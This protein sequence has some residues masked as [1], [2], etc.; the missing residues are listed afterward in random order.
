MQCPVCKSKIDEFYTVCPVCGFFGLHMDFVNKE[1]ALHWKK[2]IL[3]YYQ[4][5]WNRKQLG[6]PIQVNL[7]SADAIEVFEKYF[8]DEH[9]KYQ[10]KV[11][12]NLNEAVI[13]YAKWMSLQLFPAIS[14][15][16]NTK[17]SVLTIVA[18]GVVF[19]HDYLEEGIFYAISNNVVSVYYDSE[20][21]DCICAV[22]IDDRRKRTEFITVLEFARAGTEH[23]IF[24]FDR[25]KK[26][27]ESLYQA[28]VTFADF[29]SGDMI[30]PISLYAE[31]DDFDE[32]KKYED[33][34]EHRGLCKI[35]I[36][37][38]SSYKRQAPAFVDIYKEDSSMFIGIN[39]VK[40]TKK[41]ILPQ[42]IHIPLGQGD[43]TL[44]YD[45]DVYINESKSTVYVGSWKSYTAFRFEELA[46]ARQMFN[47][48]ALVGPCW[49]RYG[50]KE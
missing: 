15:D 20:K 11:G 24:P 7:S 40:E 6:D 2:S 18:D 43:D 23:F 50:L 47:Y 13:L 45:G 30:K 9:Y 4:A 33:Q 41:W 16:I 34:L 26:S 46:Q 22:E 21:K 48:I 3:P 27:W 42:G 31:V 37:V 1:D 38:E 25:N 17:Y 29:F 19:V 39:H 28:D 12:S 10:L 14:I 35:T 44:L 8:S 36:E 49:A 5:V 32:S